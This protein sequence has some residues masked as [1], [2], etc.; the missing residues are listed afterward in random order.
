MVRYADDFAIGFETEADAKACLEALKDRL[1]KFGLTLHPKKT[2]LIEFGR[3]SAARRER[4]GR[5]RCE[6]FDFLGFTH[7]CG[8]TR[9]NKRF[10]LWRR[11]MA[12]RLSR[13]LA[14]IKVQLRR[15]RHD[16]VGTDWTLAGKRDSGMAAIP[17]RSR[18]LNRLK[19]SHLVA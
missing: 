4:E 10:V 19:M 3:A 14:A 13:T 15:R 9:K 6:T 11:T 5:G 1:Q 8:K 16:S 12:K 7:I 18:Q 2:R 17:R